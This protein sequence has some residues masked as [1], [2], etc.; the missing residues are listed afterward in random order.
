MKIGRYKGVAR[1]MSV[2]GK[3]GHHASESPVD[4][5]KEARK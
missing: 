2:M 5:G 4:E 3:K 1:R